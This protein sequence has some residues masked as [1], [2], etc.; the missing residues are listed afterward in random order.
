MVVTTKRNALRP[1]G[2]IFAATGVILLSVAGWLANRQYTILSSWPTVQATV[3]KSRVV[4]YHG[5]RGSTTYEAEMEFRY[6]VGGSTYQTPTDAGYS[7]SSYLTMKHMVDAYPP[8]SER[9]IRYNPAD[10]ND[11]RMNAGYN[12]GFF[13]VPV[14]LGGMGIFFSGLGLVF[15]IASRS[16]RPLLCPSCGTA[17]DPG[18]RFCP[19]CATPLL[20]GSNAQTP[21]AGWAA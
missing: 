7:T 10:P 1:A 11:I 9:M 18:Q 15:L 4:R 14:L 5:R 8:G 21:P 16:A 2:A 6:T 13:F 3:V 19:N 17:V 12:F 20:G